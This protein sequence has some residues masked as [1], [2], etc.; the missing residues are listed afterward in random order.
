M[1][2]FSPTTEIIV[3]LAAPRITTSTSPD[4]VVAGA[5]IVCVRE[6]YAATVT[7]R[8]GQVDYRLFLLAGAISNVSWEDAA[9]YAVSRGGVLPTRAEMD[10]IGE[11]DNEIYSGPYWA[12]DRIDDRAM[13]YSFS[14]G[15]EGYSHISREFMARVVCRVPVDVD[16]AVDARPA[17][18][19]CAANDGALLDAELWPIDSELV[20]EI[21]DLFLQRWGMHAGQADARM[22][23]FNYQAA[24]AALEGGAA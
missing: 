16:A 18:T 23:R 7:G 20:A 19:I 3:T 1:P 14:S 9:A 6:V 24:R 11:L 12:V 17:P 10:L 4:A 22:A 13:A 5:D 15:I 21:H 8:P 2:S